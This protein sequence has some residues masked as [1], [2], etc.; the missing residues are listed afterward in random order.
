MA[1]M[2]QYEAVVIGAGSAGMSYAALLARHGKRVL[3]VDKK[4]YLGGRAATRSARE[5]GWHGSD[6]LVNYGPHILPAKG[7]AERLLDIL[8]VDKGP[9][10]KKLKL[11]YIYKNGKIIEIPAT[12]SNKF[13]FIK[14]LRALHYIRLREKSGLLKLFWISYFTSV[15]ELIAKYEKVPTIDL[16]RN[17][18]LGS[19]DVLELI[20]F[21]NGT[22][23]QNL[24]LSTCPALDFLVMLKLMLNA[25]S[26]E[27][28]IMYEVQGGYGKIF[29][30]YKSIVEGSGGAIVLG[31]KVDRLVIDDGKVSGVVANGKAVS[32]GHTVFSGV[33]R[34]LEKLLE[35]SDLDA[36]FTM[37]SQNFTPARVADL[38]MLSKKKIHEADSNWLYLVMDDDD[39]GG[40]VIFYV[41]IE[42][43]IHLKDE[44][45]YHILYFSPATGLDETV[46]GRIVDDIE[47]KFRYDF[48]ENVIW[49]ESMV[50]DVHGSERTVEYPFSERMGPETPLKNLYVIGD[51]YK[52]VT[53]GTD[54][55]AYSALLLAEK[56]LNRDFGL[57]KVL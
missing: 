7:Y 35:R 55:C 21:I 26:K 43:G 19:R 56:T 14:L 37:A 48:S 30:A 34:D 10:L 33:P 13:S 53:T 52:A 41:I 31:K 9:L 2:H 23:V 3:V 22:S 36:E 45:L 27:E 11:P 15:P 57:D 39:R 40:E 24:D 50:L 6:Y 32:A 8:R 17:H 28:T 54:G 51:S 5:W 20:T 46:V 25:I 49:S 42:E 4:D 29:D 44:Y 47:R 12:F 1:F 16:M 18:G 38:V